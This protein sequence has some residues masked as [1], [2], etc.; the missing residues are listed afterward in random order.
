MTQR[1]ALSGTTAIFLILSG[2]AQADVTGAEVWNNWKT[3]A[4]GMGQVLTPG[5]ESQ[6]GDT[7]TISNLNISMAMPEMT[8]SGDVGSIEFRDRDDGTVAITVSPNYDM[9]F[10]A[11][12]ADG[13]SVEAVMNVAQ[14]GMSIIASGGDGEITY[15]F[16]APTVTIMVDKLVADGE[17]MDLNARIVATDMNGQYVFT[18]GDI[19]TISSRLNAGNIGVDVA[20]KEPGGA[21]TFDMTIS[22][23]DVESNSDG[24]TMMM[25]NM[26]DMAAMLASGFSTEGD[27][28]HGAVT[29]KINFQD[30]SS[31]FAFDGKADSG[32]L[33]IGL[34]SQAI[35]YEVATNGFSFTMS[36]SDIPLPEVSAGFA[37]IGFGL[38]MP[39][40]KSDVPQDFG[41]YVKLDG[42]TVSDMIWGMIDQGGQ[43]PHDPATLILDLAGK[44]NWFVD[45]MDPMAQA[46]M[47]EGTTPGEI[48]ALDINEVRIAIGG[49]E[50]TGSGGFTFDNSDLETFDGIPRLPVRSI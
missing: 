41:T 26:Q 22:I 30:N 1:K 4:N 17:T 13:P 33:A 11:Q 47:A 32:S 35:N 39:L 37:E 23:S 50:L 8:V 16:L 27:F 20:A 18:E 48:H 34:N 12:P 24:T 36:G 46:E 49:A 31:N 21:G 5:S 19:P 7:L 44:A 29:Y 14:E 10:K 28:S 25:G 3:A 45:I 40:G 38:L 15:D 2:A 6:S 42:I 9:A 43:L